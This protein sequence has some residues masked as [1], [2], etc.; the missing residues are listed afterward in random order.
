[1]EKRARFVIAYERDERTMRELCED[2]GISRECGYRWLRRYRQYGLSGLVELTIVRWKGAA[3]PGAD[4]SAG[5]LS[6]SHRLDESIPWRVA[7]QQS[8]PPLHQPF[9]LQRSRLELETAILRLK[10]KQCPGC[11][12]PY[13]EILKII[14]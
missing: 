8:P 11:A 10:M 6:P 1:M 12:R 2:F 3:G 13:K 14:L 7:L 5:L 9:H 4:Q